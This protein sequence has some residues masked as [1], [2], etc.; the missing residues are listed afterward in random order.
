MPLDPD[1]YVTSTDNVMVDL[2]LVPF[3]VKMV[4]QNNNNNKEMKQ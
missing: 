3:P 1:M 4:K 2:L